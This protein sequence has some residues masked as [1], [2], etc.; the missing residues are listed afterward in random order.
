ML[1]HIISSTMP[2]LFFKKMSSFA[3]SLSPSSPCPFSHL[4]PLTSSLSPWFYFSLSS[5]SPSSSLRRGSDQVTPL[6]PSVEHPTTLHL[7][8]LEGKTT[9][10]TGDTLSGVSLCASVDHSNQ[11]L[12]LKPLMFN[13]HTVM[14]NLRND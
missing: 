9:V 8:S 12:V 1:S 3:F 7:R 14:K 4:C 11:V 10:R 5:S 6:V 13:I 2:H